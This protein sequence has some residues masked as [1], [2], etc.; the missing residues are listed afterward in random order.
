MAGVCA[1]RTLHKH[2]TGGEG[3]FLLA[4]CLGFE[5]SDA[6]HKEIG[7]HK[8]TLLLRSSS[9]PFGCS[10][11]KASQPLICFRRKETWRAR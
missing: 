7:I 10:C 11:S 8:F 1:L 6:A 4:T 5:V 3:F 2:A 9:S